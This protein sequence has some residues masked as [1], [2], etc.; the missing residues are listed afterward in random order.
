M[1]TSSKSLYAPSAV[2]CRISRIDSRNPPQLWQPQHYP[3]SRSSSR[4]KVRVLFNPALDVLKRMLM[5]V[6]DYL[7][8][9]AALFEWAESYDSKVCIYAPVTSPE[10]TLYHSM[11][12]YLLLL[13][14][15]IALSSSPT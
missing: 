6:L 10:E 13:I 4:F 3:R 2:D 8:L 15:L 11:C 14:L 7:G 5:C 1:D 9:N 12:P